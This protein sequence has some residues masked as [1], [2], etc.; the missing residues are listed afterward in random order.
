LKC[1]NSLLQTEETV[2]Q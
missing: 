2:W 1:C